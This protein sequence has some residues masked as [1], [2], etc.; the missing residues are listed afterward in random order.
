MPLGQ[1]WI[2]E[3]IT[4]EMTKIMNLFE[5]RNLKLVNSGFHAQINFSE[6]YL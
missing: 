6:N 1:G 3:W 4:Q 5:A 2:K